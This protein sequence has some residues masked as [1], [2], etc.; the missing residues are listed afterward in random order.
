MNLFESFD[1][2]VNDEFVEKFKSYTSTTHGDLNVMVKG[3]FYTLLAGMIRKTY[4]DMSAGML[5]SQIQENAKKIDLPSNLSSIFSQPTVV[6]KIEADG[7]KI[8][9]QV[10]PA[11]K[12]PLLSM[13][14]TY[15]GVSKANTSLASG[16]IANVI[17]TMFSKDMD[18]DK[19]VS[20]LRQHHEPLIQAIPEGLLEKM[21]PSLGLHDLLGSKPVP[22]KK[23]ENPQPSKNRE[24]MPIE[25]PSSAPA[26]GSHAG[27]II[28]IVVGLALLGGAVY[29]YLNKDGDINFFSKKEVPVE[30]IEA[31]LADS[32]EVSA[33]AALPTAPKTITG[34]EFSEFKSYILNKN[35]AAGKE[36]E[37]K[38]ITFVTDSVSLPPTSVAVVDSIA[39]LMKENSRLQIKITAF[40]GSGETAFNNKRAFSVKRVL[41]RAGVQGVRIDAVS[42]GIGEDF[43]KIKV[44]TK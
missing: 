10:F 29:W 13:I 44:I 7:S 6:N 16:I 28:S 32:L 35:Q 40:S 20:I 42:G 8:I 33:P 36:F 23:V 12:S 27:A 37:F 14:S 21:I 39:A 18:R 22:L 5:Y 34:S 24:E 2:I 11:Y 30:S 41:T 31:P 38:S 17:V 1:E 9:S 25:Y 3:I 4:S 15:S 26:S 19:M 43:A